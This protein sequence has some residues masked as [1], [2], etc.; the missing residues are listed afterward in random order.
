MNDAARTD[1]HSGPIARIA[2]LIACLLFGDEA[3]DWIAPVLARALPGAGLV[4]LSSLLAAVLG[5]GAPLLTAAV[6]DQGIMARDMDA[7]LF[8]AAASFAVGLG[9]VGLGVL[10]SMIHL[11]ASARMLTDLRGRIMAASLARDPRLPDLPVGETAARIDGDSAEIQRFAFD[12][13]LVAVGA[14]FRL[15]GGTILMAMLDWRLTLLP[16]LAAPLELWF[17][18]RVRRETTCRAETVRESRGELASHMTESLNVRPMLRSLGASPMRLA[19]FNDLQN[20]QVSAL[21]HQRIWSEMV[22]TVSQ[23]LT[24]IT[25]GGVLLAGGWLVIRGDW[26][27]GALVAFMAYTGMMAGP[28]RNLLGLYHAQAKARVALDRLSAVMASAPHQ[29]ASAIV[30]VEAVAAFRAARALGG[31]HPPASFLIHAGEKVLIDGPSGI[32]KSRLMSALT[33]SAALDCGK[34]LI[35][36][37]PVEDLG[38][39]DLTKL[40]VHVEQ[41]PML[42]RGTLGANLRLAAPI[43]KD[44]ALWRVLA[45]AELSEWADKRSG[46][47]TRI[48]ESGADLS[49]GLR[50]RIALARALLRPAPIMIFDES[51][52]EIDAPACWRILASIDVAYADRARVFIAH[53]GPAREGAF[54]QRITLS[55]SAPD[56][57]RSLGGTPNQRERALVNAV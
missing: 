8:W 32:G 24:A 3:K 39:T 43:A 46:L 10:N 5:L 26:Q 28:L 15:A 12:S 22:G 11:R 55:S 36:G 49:G 19:D 48:G 6:I 7:L 17:L 37:I 23:I 41:R 29:P 51:F 2:G 57:R 1:R 52:S 54:D 53:S 30:P 20:S 9:A 25:R 44:V 40:V 16:A 14:I 45:I 33:G 27:I 4:L 56:L 47:A 18:S 38:R 31:L 42:L 50:Q 13:V 21:I 34:V 35:G